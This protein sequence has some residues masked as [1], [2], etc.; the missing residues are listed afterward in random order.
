MSEEKCTP[1]SPNIITLWL[2][3]IAGTY[4]S[5]T[6]K[7]YLYGVRAWHIIHGISWQID[8][9]GTDALLQAVTRLAPES[10]KRKKRLPYTISFITTLLEDLNPN[11]PLDTAVAGC[12]TTTFYG[13]ARLGEFTVPRLT[14]F[15][16]LDFITRSD[17]HIGQD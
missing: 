5:A 4:S 2:S 11:K 7:N 9:A 17:I 16:P 14:D 13:R 6:I 10:S 15:N 3:T 8:E 1:A 12:L